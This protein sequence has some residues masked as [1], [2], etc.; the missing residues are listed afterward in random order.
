MAC[1]QMRER[2]CGE[3]EEQACNSLDG[4]MEPGAC[5]A[6]DDADGQEK[7]PCEQLK[8]DVDDH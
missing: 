3:G 2:R 1:G 7:P 5:K 4:R 8:K 6:E